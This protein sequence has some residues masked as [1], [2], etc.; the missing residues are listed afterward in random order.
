MFSAFSNCCSVDFFPRSLQSLCSSAHL[1][2]GLITIKHSMSGSQHSCFS[3]WHPLF[4]G[5]AIY[6]PFEASCLNCTPTNYIEHAHLRETIFLGKPGSKCLFLS[7]ITKKPSTMA[8][9]P[10]YTTQLLSM[11]DA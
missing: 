4:Q 5:F 9:Y 11:I 10:S 8:T 7:G 2:I 6:F 1:D 3:A